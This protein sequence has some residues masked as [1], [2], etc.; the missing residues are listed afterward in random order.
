MLLCRITT[1]ES[2]RE[3]K[4]LSLIWVHGVA[5]FRRLSSNLRKF[6][7]YFS[8]LHPCNSSGVSQGARVQPSADK[9]KD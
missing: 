1:Y 4:N 6:T 7:A 9:I 3:I 2:T 5:F 8:H